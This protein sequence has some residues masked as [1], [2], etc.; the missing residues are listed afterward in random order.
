[1]TFL[2]YH[3][4]GAGPRRALRS[5]ILRHDND[6]GFDPRTPGWPVPRLRVSCIVPYY[7]TGTL[8]TECAARLAAALHAYQCAFPADPPNTQI[9]VID[10][11]SATHPFPDDS[12]IGPVTVIRLPENRGR[13]AARN[14]GL[15]ASR[16]FDVALFVDSD[17]LVHPEQVIRTCGLWRPPDH[18]AAVQPPIVATLFSTYRAGPHDFDPERALASATVCADW[19][20]SCRFQPSWVADPGDWLYV[21]R[22]FDLVTGTDFFRRWHGTVGP[23]LLPNMVLGGCFAVPVEAALDAGGFDESFTGYGWTETSLIARLIA[24]GVRVIPQVSVPA[25]HVEHNPAHHNQRIRD[26]ALAAAHRRF[27]TEFLA[28]DLD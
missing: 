13:V 5:A 16:D 26:T 10:D 1:M 14:L 17:V 6:F 21:G 28:H 7:E 19:R 9:V 15:Q 12:T 22:R 27:Y 18:D 2:G 4:S 23:W 24:C 11:G 20:W 25:V 3:A 8:A